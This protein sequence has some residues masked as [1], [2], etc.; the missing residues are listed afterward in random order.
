MPNDSIRCLDSSTEPTVE[1][2]SKEIGCLSFF[3]QGSL[4]GTH[5]A[6]DWTSSKSKRGL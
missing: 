4:N 3:W 6:G 5:F 1:H 2:A